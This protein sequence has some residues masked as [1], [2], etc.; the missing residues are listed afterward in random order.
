LEGE[1]VGKGPWHKNTY[2]S[3]T[4]KSSPSVL[5]YACDLERLHRFWPGRDSHIPFTRYVN[6]PAFAQPEFF[7]HRH[8]PRFRCPPN[9]FL[10]S[11][12]CVLIALLLPSGEFANKKTLYYTLHYTDGHFSPDFWTGQMELPL[13]SNDLWSWLQR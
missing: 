9:F 5:I 11:S 4:I 13:S 8:L 3:K 12:G 1:S 7:F 6:T 2:S 10:T